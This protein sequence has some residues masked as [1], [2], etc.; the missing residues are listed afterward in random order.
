MPM[1]PDTERELREIYANASLNDTE[2]NVRPKYGA[3]IFAG[4]DYPQT[5]AGF[6]GQVRAVKHL[7]ATIAEATLRS[8]PRLDHILLASGLH[9]IGKTTLAMLIASEAGVGLTT[10]SGALTINDARDVLMGM[11]DGD[12][13]FWDEIHMAVAGNRTRADWL[14]P[15][16]TDGVLVTKSGREP[17]PNVTVLA[18]TTDL[19]KLPQT[20][21]SRFMV[22]P[23]LVGYTE[24]EGLLLVDNL[25]VRMGVILAPEHREPIAVAANCNPRDI[26]MVLTAYRSAYALAESDMDFDG[27]VDLELAFEWAG[28]TADGLSTV[29]V[30]ILLVLLGT[31]DHTAS[32]D[33]IG[34][35]LG[36][37]GPLRHHEQT[38]LQRGLVDITGRGRT[39]TDSG[40]NRAILAVQKGSI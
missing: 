5:W 11:Q 35:K 15:L 30:E 27:S 22:R 25:A 28:V 1:H 26:R 2:T 6:V 16:L 36:E 21:I 29:A 40:R 20:L 14:L 12:I 31:T 37:P 38:L 3:E 33:S 8:A 19:G 23:T 34:A 13:L 32:I 39:L 18:A 7:Q 17:M 9:G 24:P 10:V 4:T